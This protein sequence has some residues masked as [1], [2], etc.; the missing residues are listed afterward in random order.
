M[1]CGDNRRSCSGRGSQRRP[2][3]MVDRRCHAAPSG[4]QGCRYRTAFDECC[5]KEVISVASV[6]A[7]DSP[8]EDS[9]RLTS[10]VIDGCTTTVRGGLVMLVQSESSKVSTE[11][12]SGI[13]I[14]SARSRDPDHLQ[15]TASRSGPPWRQVQPA[16]MS[17]ALHPECTSVSRGNSPIGRGRRHRRF[18]RLPPQH[19]HLV[20]Q[21]LSPHRSLPR[22]PPRSTSARR[23]ARPLC[24]QQFT[25]S[26]SFRLP[27]QR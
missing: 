4:K 5:G 20:P 1:V 27:R 19:R 15:H 22:W 12:S 14:P 8:G 24:D 26:T 25:V 3:P 7:I 13:D 18:T 17:R 11:T 2:W 23:P 10:D 9:C 21:H 16:I 6:V